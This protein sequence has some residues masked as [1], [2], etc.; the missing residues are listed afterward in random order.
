MRRHSLACLAAAIIGC[1]ARPSPKDP[2]V[3]AAFPATPASPGDSLPRQLRVVTFNVHRE[4][5]DKVIDGIRGDA[6]LRAA[7]LIVLQ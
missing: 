7:D 5:G 1:H 3:E 6:A 4:A 2:S